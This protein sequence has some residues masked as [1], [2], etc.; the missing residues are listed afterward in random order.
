MGLNSPVGVSPTGM[1]QLLY[2]YKKPDMAKNEPG[3]VVGETPTTG[4][5]FILQIHEI[6]IWN[7]VPPNNLQQQ[8]EAPI[9]LP[10]NR[11]TLQRIN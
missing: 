2:S 1:L 10:T 4:A 9:F 3:V 5:K 11:S 6:I 7:N 8:G